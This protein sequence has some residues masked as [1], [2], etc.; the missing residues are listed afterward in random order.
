YATSKLLS[1]LATRELARRLPDGMSIY[2]ADP[3]MVKHTGFNSSAG[4]LMRLTAPLFK[5]F[6][7]TPE[8]GV[9]TLVWLASVDPAPE[10][11]GGF[12]TNNQPVTPS[13]LAR[14]AAL[15]RAVYDRTADLLDIEAREPTRS[16][17]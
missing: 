8:K 12:F 3:G 15:A 11:T 7:T 17:R 2:N 13:Q 14:D 1:L 4:G 16:V 5:P 10:P 9:Q 6:A